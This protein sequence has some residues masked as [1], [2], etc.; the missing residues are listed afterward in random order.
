MSLKPHLN[1]VRTKEDVC[2]EIIY[3]FIDDIFAIANGWSWSSNWCTQ[4]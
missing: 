1:L 2:F 4:W 3:R